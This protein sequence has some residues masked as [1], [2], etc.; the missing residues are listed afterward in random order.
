MHFFQGTY[1]GTLEDVNHL[2]LIG[3]LNTARYKW[4]EFTGREIKFKPA[5]FYLGV[6]DY[7][8]RNVEG[9]GKDTRTDVGSKTAEG[10]HAGEGVKTVEGVENRGPSSVDEPG[11]SSSSEGLRKRLPTPDNS[12]NGPTP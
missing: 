4:A 8:A 2:D 7:L 5:T 1:L 10:T 6:A 3:W 12:S 11:Q 9:Q